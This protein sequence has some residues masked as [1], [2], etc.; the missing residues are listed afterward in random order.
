MSVTKNE[1]RREQ[2]MN[3]AEK[4]FAERGFHDTKISDI[5]KAAKLSETTIYEYFSSKEEILFS[6]PR[7]R[8][9][10]TAEDIKFIFLHV[11]GAV[12]KLRVFISVYLWFWK[13]HESYASIAL[14]NLKQNRKFVDTEIAAIVKDTYGMVPEVLHEGIENGEFKNDLDIS[15]TT[16]MIIGTVDYIATNSLLYGVS[17]DLMEYVDPIHDQI[18]HGI[19]VQPK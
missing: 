16:A 14:L 1:A 7:E 19:A 4:I 3:A 2:I 17:R 8:T 5:A 15:V 13:T 6:I 18:V 11:A 10:K 9:L 12:N